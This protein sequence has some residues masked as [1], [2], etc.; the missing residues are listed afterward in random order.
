V[1]VCVCVCVY[2]WSLCWVKRL[3]SFRSDWGMVTER[4]RSSLCLCKTFKILELILHLSWSKNV[5]SIYG[6]T[7]P[8]LWGFAVKSCQRFWEV[9]KFLLLSFTSLTSLNLWS[10][11]VKLKTAASFGTHTHTHNSKEACKT[12]LYLNTKQ[13]VCSS[14]GVVHVFILRSLPTTFESS[15]AWIFKYRDYTSV[16]FKSLRSVRFWRDFWS[17]VVSYTH[18]IG[19]CYYNLK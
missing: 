10:A 7:L 12:K 1:W 18:L 16:L 19:K 6:E 11:H 9:W 3:Y 14:L 15:D 17:I 5:K 8:C 13:Q 2:A 4:G